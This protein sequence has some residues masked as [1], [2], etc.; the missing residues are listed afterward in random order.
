MFYL[1]DVVLAFACEHNATVLVGNPFTKGN[2]SYFVDLTHTQTCVSRKM[3]TLH[4]WN[5]LLRFLF[6]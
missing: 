1:H 5:E 4:L 3:I 2:E 6:L